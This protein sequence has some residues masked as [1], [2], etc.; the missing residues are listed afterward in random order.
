MHPDRRRPKEGVNNE[1]PHPN[2]HPIDDVTAERLRVAFRRFNPFMVAMWRLGLGRWMNVWPAG[3]G[4]IFVLGHTGRRTGR[5]RWTPLNYAIV[6]G[7]LYC[8][9]GFGTGSDWYRNVMAEPRVEVWP[10][11]ERWVGIVED[12]SDHPERIRLL[13]EVLVASGFAARAA[14]IDPLRMDDETLAAATTPYCLLRIRRAAGAE[15]LPAHPRP[16]DL[17]WWWAV[18]VASA[19]ALAA[20]P[21]LR[22]TSPDSRCSPWPRR[23]RRSAYR[24]R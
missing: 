16:G 7:E 2:P 12:I 6:D 14:G 15:P 4:R 10:P 20:R 22:R 1:G 24:A 5:R 13:R 9:A 8:T 23:C 18:P 3:S 21:R 17:S 19:A 11:G